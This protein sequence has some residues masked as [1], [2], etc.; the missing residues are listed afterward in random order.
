M[1]SPNQLFLNASISVSDAL[2]PV[3]ASML[4]LVILV[5]IGNAT[6][7]DTNLMTSL[8]F[9]MTDVANQLN[10]NHMNHESFERSL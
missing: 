5:C 6:M 10:N 8:H 1:H 2:I 3:L 7:P 9:N 4:F